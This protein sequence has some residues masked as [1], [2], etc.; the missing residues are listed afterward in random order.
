[1]KLVVEF[2]TSTSPGPG[3]PDGH[4]DG[5]KRGAGSCP[6]GRGFDAGRTWLARRRFLFAPTYQ[7]F[8]RLAEDDHH[9]FAAS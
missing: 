8:A 9:P 3:A 5:F 6:P 1:M 2:L 4:H 7:N